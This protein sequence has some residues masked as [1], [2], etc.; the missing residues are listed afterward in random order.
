MTGLRRLDDVLRYHFGQLW[1]AYPETEKMEPDM[2][3][4]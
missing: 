1:L 4:R 3:D 2:N